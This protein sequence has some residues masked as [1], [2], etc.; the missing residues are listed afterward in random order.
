MRYF[1]TIPGTDVVTPAEFNQ[2]ADE[3]QRLGTLTATAPLVL[4]QGGYGVNIALMGTAIWGKIKGLAEVTSSSL[5]G[6]QGQPYLFDRV[7]WSDTA[8]TFT[9]YD[10]G[11]ICFEVNGNFVPD[12]VIVKIYEDNNTYI[13]SY[14][15]GGSGSTSGSTSMS[16]QSF[17]IPFAQYVTCDN[18]TLEVVQ[19]YLNITL[20]LG[21]T[22]SVDDQPCNGSGSGG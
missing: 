20:P 7:T 22:L 6:S 16:G 12:D 14:C 5:S 17:C 2:L 9:I 18:G 4:Q 19:K 13:F 15:C 1:P 21:S 11:G 10:E 3:V 8:K